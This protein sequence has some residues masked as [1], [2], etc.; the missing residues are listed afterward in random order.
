MV[1][2]DQPWEFG[3]YLTWN[4]SITWNNLW[5]ALV[6]QQSPRV[7]WG[8]GPLPDLSSGIPDGG[9]TGTEHTTTM[10]NRESFTGCLP[11]K[12]K[13]RLAARLDSSAALS[14]VSSL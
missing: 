4:N 14:S 3:N 6:S 5:L 11:G 8:G 2:W 1:P 13:L 10:K 7:D 9:I 12:G